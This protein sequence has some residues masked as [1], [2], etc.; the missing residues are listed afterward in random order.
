M[1]PYAYLINKRIQY[2]QQQ[3]KD[4]ASISTVALDTGFAD[5][6]HF[7]RTFKRLV[8]ATPNEYRYSLTSTIN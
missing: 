6:A 2:S 4:G 1:T 3:L 5:Q 7:Q 8:A